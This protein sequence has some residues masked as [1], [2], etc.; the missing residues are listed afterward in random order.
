MRKFLI[1]G[2]SIL[3][4]GCFFLILTVIGVVESFGSMERLAKECNKTGSSCPLVDLW[5]SLPYGIPSLTLFPLGMYI[6]A[7]SKT[8][9]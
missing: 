1:I 5:G 8:K 3:V 6:L 7:V 4:V 9:N 2:I